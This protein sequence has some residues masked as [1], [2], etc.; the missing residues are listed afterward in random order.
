MEEVSKPASS[1]RERKR[2]RFTLKLAVYRQSVRLG[3]NPLETH[4]QNFIF[5]LKTCGYSPYVTSSLMRGWVCH[6]QLLPVL[7]SA[8]T[9]RSKSRGTHDIL[10]SQIRDSPNLEGQVPAFISPRNRMASSLYSAIPE[11][12]KTPFILIYCFHGNVFTS[13]TK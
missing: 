13:P 4:N 12:Q 7:A 3:D 6:L 9:L 2:V 1:E 8:V 10:L 11:A 5:Q